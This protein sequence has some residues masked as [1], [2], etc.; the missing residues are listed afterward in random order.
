MPTAWWNAQSANNTLSAGSSARFP[1]VDPLTSTGL[2]KTWEAGFTVVRMILDVAVRASSINL[3]AFG[4]FG[5]LVTTTRT[6]ID[7]IL[8]LFDYYLHQNFVVQSDT[9]DDPSTYRKSYD[10][11]TARRVRGSERA[12]EFVITNNSSSSVSLFWSASA[13]LLLKA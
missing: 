2:P 13:R 4:A 7:V 10:I 1:L 12:L 9:V 6:L 11:R 5:V 3:T 8:D